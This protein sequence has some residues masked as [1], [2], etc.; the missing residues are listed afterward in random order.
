MPNGFTPG[1]IDQ[2]TLLQLGD[3]WVDLKQGDSPIT[4]WDILSVAGEY[5]PGLWK[6]EVTKG[7]DLEIVKPAKVSSSTPGTPTITDKGYKP[8]T[9]K[10]TGRIWDPTDWRYLKELLPIILPKKDSTPKS[11][12]DITHP[13]LEL[14]G[15]SQVIFTSVR[16][17]PITSQ[18]LT[19]ELDVMEWFPLTP[20]KVGYKPLKPNAARLTAADNAALEPPTPSAGP[21]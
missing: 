12:F 17:P 20:D 10:L 11:A 7:T 16:I 9:G 19:I 5:W 21:K 8:T 4:P 1:E 3:F 18:I 13:A 15:L 2:T 14:V 6:A